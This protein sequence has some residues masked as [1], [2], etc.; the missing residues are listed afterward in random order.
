MAEYMRYR[1]F[2]ADIEPTAVEDDTM[3][4][5]RTASSPRRAT[6]GCHSFL[7]GTA[8]W[9]SCARGRMAMLRPMWA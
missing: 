1:H 8:E 9:R 3:P 4:I 5:S 6:H 2:I 7:V